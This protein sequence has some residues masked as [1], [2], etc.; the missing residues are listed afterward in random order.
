MPACP[1][2]YRY[3]PSVFARAADLQADTLYVVGGVYG[4]R[5][6]LETVLGLRAKERGSTALRFSGDFNWFNSDDEGFEAINTA[7][8]SHRALRGNV[9][10]EV[11]SDDA[12]GGCGCGYP[13]S[14]PEADVIAPMKFSSS[15]AEPPGTFPFC[16][17]AWRN[18]RCTPLRKL[19]SCASALSM[20]MRSRW[21]AGSSM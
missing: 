16:G 5:R 14:V 3:A 20:V 2:H 1:L 19:G 13:D 11:A 4:N 17:K 12:N 10:T 6:A 21:Q 9:E 7:V 15:C 18:F 8:L